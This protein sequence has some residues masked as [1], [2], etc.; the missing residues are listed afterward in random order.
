MPIVNVI[1]PLATSL[2]VN[3]LARLST[4][5]KGT[6]N[7]LR[8]RIQRRV[9]MH[10][11][12][13][14]VDRRVTSMASIVGARLQGGVSWL[15]RV[16]PQVKRMARTA[17]PRPTIRQSRFRVKGGVKGSVQMLVTNR[18]GRESHPARASLRLVLEGP[19]DT[20][21]V[22]MEFRITGARTRVASVTKRTEGTGKGK[23]MLL[24]VFHTALARVAL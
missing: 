14:A 13:R 12:T 21:T 4:A 11:L 22:T 3:L 5:S 2:P 17:T 9:G 7:G 23:H 24:V 16:F 20:L 19:E 6:R 1:D 18:W 8:P 15:Q 10:L